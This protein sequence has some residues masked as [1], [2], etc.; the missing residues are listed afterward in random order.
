MNFASVYNAR[1]LLQVLI[2]VTAVDVISVK[3]D[4]RTRTKL[5]GVALMSAVAT[6]AVRSSD[7][8]TGLIYV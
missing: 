5:P 4:F 2:G 6:A 1:Q 8:P 7:V 3:K